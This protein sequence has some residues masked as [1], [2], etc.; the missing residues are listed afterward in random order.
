MPEGIRVR[1]V[2]GVE[3]WNSYTVSGGTLADVKIYAPSESATLTYPAFA[4]NGAY[5]VTIAGILPASGI[6]G[7]VLDTAL[8]YPRV[9]VSAT[10][11]VTLPRKFVLVVI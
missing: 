9:T 8:G 6:P 11:A 7:V 5:L 1:D 10:T 2:N 4:G 3:I